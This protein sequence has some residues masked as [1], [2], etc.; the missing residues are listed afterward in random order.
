MQ[1]YSILN[2]IGVDPNDVKSYEATEV[3][4]DEELIYITLKPTQTR[5]PYCGGKAVLKEYKDVMIKCKHKNRVKTIIVLTKP[6]YVCH[7]CHKTYTHSTNQIYENMVS[8]NTINLIHDLLAEQL[9]YKMISKLSDVPLTTVIK[10]F[11]NYSVVNNAVISE[12]ICIDEFKNTNDAAGKFACILINFDDH[13]IIDIIESRTLPYLREYF[14]KIPE[15]IRKLVK[16]IISDMYDGYLTIAHE[17]FPNAI[18][19]IDPFHYVRYLTDAVQAIRQDLLKNDEDLSDKSWMGEHWKLLTRDNINLSEEEKNKEYSRLSDGTTIRHVDR[20]ERFVRQN[21]E[22]NY[23]YHLLQNFYFDSKMINDSEAPGIIRFY[24]EQMK[25]SGY[26]E[27]IDAG[28]TWENYEQEIVNSFIRY[29]GKRL[30][31]GPVEGANNI[32]K[33]II[34]FSCGLRNFNRLKKRAI[35]IVNKPYKK[36][37]F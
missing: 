34:K 10:I 8:Q 7:S 37:R 22:L 32:I 17:F 36:G 3:V 30:S 2:E 6:R 28:K 29:K 4:G 20:I 13:K 35:L 19:A 12:A 23:S 26:K 21:N 14:S 5:C 1:N 16:Y 33:S 31:N 25:G 24:I 9:S 11:D 18:V 27:L 15:P